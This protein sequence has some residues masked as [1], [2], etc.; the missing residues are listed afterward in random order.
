MAR[1]SEY[2]RNHERGLRMSRRAASYS[3]QEVARKAKIANDKRNKEEERIRV[4]SSINLKK[5]QYSWFR[6]WYIFS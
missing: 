1:L 5:K 3:E 2:R 4:A 6:D